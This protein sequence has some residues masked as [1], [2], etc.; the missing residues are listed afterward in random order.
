MAAPSADERLRALLSGVPA[1]LRADRP[2]AAALPQMT[3]LA[4]VVFDAPYA[5]GA[6]VRSDGSLAA[7]AFAGQPREVVE[8]LTAEGALGSVF[9]RLR[10]AADP[11]LV[12]DL[13]A[14]DAPM[15]VPPEHPPVRSLLGG[16]WEADG[17]TVGVFFAAHP[18]PDAF[19]A[20]HVGLMTPLGAALG[21]AVANAS[22]LRDA[23]HARRW[24][25]EAAAVTRELLSGPVEAPLGLIGDRARELA[26]AD[27]VALAVHDSSSEALRF[28]YVRGMNAE[29]ALQGTTVPL[30]TST[31]ARRVID[32]GRAEVMDRLPP[33]EGSGLREM[34]GLELG[35][36][37]LLP[38]QGADAVLGVLLLAR[39]ADSPGFTRTDVEI[40]GG[41][42]SHAAITLELASARE[43]AQHMELLEERNR[44]GRDL[45][46][47][48]V[49][50]LYATGMTLQQTMPNLSGAPRERVAAA[51][52]TLD[53]TIRQ[54][55]NTI[56]SLHSSEEPDA[57]LEEL[58]TAIA[59]EATP[60]LGFAPL[61]ALEAPSGEV[62]GPLAAD[63]AACLREGMSNTV[64]HSR[65]RQV[66]IVGSVEPEGLHLM[67]RDD[68]VGIQS[69]RRSGLANLAART[70]QYGGTFEVQTP[71]EGGT[72]LTWQVPLQRR[73]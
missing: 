43:V 29:Q 62:S 16:R 42:A 8:R 56:L 66:E 24:M 57:T 33:E 70:K 58:V 2:P 32:T 31:W 46:D 39:E 72:V 52:A 41:F 71:P 15:R 63:L 44:I 11:V 17:Q 19:T 35:P 4:R 34:G 20:R 14:A 23:L 54:I 26:D 10:C 30:T 55:R 22:L 48:V 7:I 9:D 61:V 50:R 6:L 59:R 5:G 67:L 27:L 47:H 69:D 28:R 40:A 51:I 60:L 25:H 36:A 18:E 45:H 73:R 21:A 12:A 64:R 53:D 49:Q 37:M 38:L 1:L 68:G 13:D 65:A 3:D